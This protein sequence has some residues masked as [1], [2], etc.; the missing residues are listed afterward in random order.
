MIFI[1]IYRD[2][3]VFFILYDFLL[4][5]FIIELNFDGFNRIIYMIV[6]LSVFL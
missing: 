1:M 5:E 3:D 2:I 4:L 6:Y